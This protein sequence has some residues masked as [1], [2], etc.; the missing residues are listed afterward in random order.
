MLG[1][2]FCCVV[3]AMNINPTD[4]LKLPFIE[5]VSTEY[6]FLV[7]LSLISCLIIL[8]S[9]SHL[10]AMRIQTYYY[11]FYPEP[12]DKDYFDLAVEPSIFR[13]A[14]ISWMIRNRKVFFRNID[15]ANKKWKRFELITYLILKVLVFLIL[16]FFPLVILFKVVVQSDIFNFCNSTSAFIRFPLIVLII[17]SVIS[18][19]IVWKNSFEHTFIKVPKQAFK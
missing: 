4:K 3:V 15:D 12:D 8:F 18:F 9:S 17:L 11:K 14:P 2:L 1:L 7:A 10:M 16:Y 13:M 6:Y 19:S 5:E